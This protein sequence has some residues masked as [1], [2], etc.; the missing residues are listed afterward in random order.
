MN[1]NFSFVGVNY[2][3]KRK[4]YQKNIL[5]LDLD[6]FFVEPVNIF[7]IPEELDYLLMVPHK[8]LFLRDLIQEIDPFSINNPKVSL[9][10]FDYGENYFFINFV[11]KEMDLNNFKYIIIKEMI[12]ENSWYLSDLRF[13]NSELQVTLLNGNNY[14]KKTIFTYSTNEGKMSMIETFN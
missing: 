10:F 5:N 4:I 6:K 8:N 1:K 12:N 13:H 14:E 2:R 3:N 7:E 11:L 9:K